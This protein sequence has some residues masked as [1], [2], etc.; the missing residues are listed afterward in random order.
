MKPFTKIAR[1]FLKDFL[2]E[3]DVAFKK[4]D[5]ILCPFEVL[6][7]DYLNKQQSDLVNLFEPSIRVLANVYGTEQVDEF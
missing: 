2:T 7:V 3:I 5:N 4:S 6:N 1:P